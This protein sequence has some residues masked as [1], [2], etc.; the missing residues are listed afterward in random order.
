MSAVIL[1]VRYSL[2]WLIARLGASR[3]LYRLALD[4]YL[5]GNA[6]VSVRSLERAIQVSRPGRRAELA[7]DLGDFQFDLQ[8]FLTASMSYQRALDEEDHNA[9]ALRGKG[10]S[11]HAMGAGSEAVYYYVSLLQQDPKDVDVMLNLALVLIWSGR[12]DD[13]EERIAEAEAVTP[14]SPDV[15]EV[16]SE[17][18]YTR[19]DIDE[20]IAIL[21]EVVERF[22]ERCEPKRVL[23]TYL[24]TVGR[25]EEAGRHFEMALECDPDDPQLRLALTAYYRDVGD[26]AAVVRHAGEAVDILKAR[27]SA[28]EELAQAYWNLA[29]GHYM[30]DD[31]KASIRASK[32]AVRLAPQMWG[33]R[34]DLALA[35]LCAGD[36]TAAED[37][38]QLVAQMAM[39]ATELRIVAI[40]DLQQAIV[41]RS[42]LD[43]DTAGRM[44]DLLRQREET[45][46]A[47]ATS[48]S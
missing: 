8:D 13:A 12:F 41:S 24:H 11:L 46:D 9:R 47:G 44:L 10:L 45:L 48:A 38:Y 14:D 19:G 32:E 37:N 23:G 29:W 18:A 1:W 42:E 35:Q 33:V 3:M 7:C 15:L 39:D 16:R 31:L 26:G 6:A 34:A 40:E 22:P 43:Q 28:S 17:L 20:G 2:L 36:T 5:A 25:M 27:I 4:A 30:L 21:E